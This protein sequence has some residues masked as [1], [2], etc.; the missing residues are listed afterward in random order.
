MQL[1]KIKYQETHDF[2]ILY[3]LI[4]FLA[5]CNYTVIFV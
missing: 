2:H 1:H 4:Q 5:I 3:H